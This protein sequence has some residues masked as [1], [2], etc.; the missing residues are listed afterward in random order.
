MNAR[1]FWLRTTVA[2]ASG[3]DRACGDK[4]RYRTY[5]LA[6]EAARAVSGK[7]ENKYYPV[8]PYPCP[9]CRGYHIGKL[10]SKE[11]QQE[12]ARKLLEGI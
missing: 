7:P 3:L 8:D 11:G 4:Y 1:E 6:E 2:F 5:A 9:W 10:V 12:L